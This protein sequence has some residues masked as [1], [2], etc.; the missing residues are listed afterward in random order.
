M[1]RLVLMTLLPVTLATADPA[2]DVLVKE[3]LVHASPGALWQAWA[4]EEGVRTFFAPA[5]NIGQAVNGSYEILFSP[6][7]P[8]GRRGAED[9]HILALEPNRRIAFSWDAPPRWPQIRANR[10]FV[11]VT[12]YPVGESLTRVRLR[13]LGWGEGVQ[14][15]QT[16][17]YFEGAWEVVLKRLQYR[18]ENGPVDWDNLPDHLWYKG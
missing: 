13:H 3:V 14:W 10:T 16:H 8:E 7:G 4:T 15:Q 18:F 1:T 12:F 17:D 6:D 5:A 2:E 9:N 11:D